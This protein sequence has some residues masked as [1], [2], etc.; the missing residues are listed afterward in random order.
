MAWI[1]H[2]A[3]LTGYVV[4]FIGILGIAGGTGAWVIELIRRDTQDLYPEYAW[5][6]DQPVPPSLWDQLQTGPDAPDESGEPAQE[7][8]ITWP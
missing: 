6:R 8:R 3:A 2:A 4:W 7:A 5:Q 1:P